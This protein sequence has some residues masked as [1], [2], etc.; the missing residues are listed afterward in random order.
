MRKTLDLKAGMS[1]SMYVRPFAVGKEGFGQWAINLHFN[2][3]L[4]PANVKGSTEFTLS[5]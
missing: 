4:G 2:S 5:C 3:S 1:L